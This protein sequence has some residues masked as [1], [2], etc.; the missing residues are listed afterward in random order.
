LINDY[1]KVRNLEEACDLLKSGN[2]TVIGGGTT[3]FELYERG[4]LQDV[5]VFVDL[6]KAGLDYIL[7][8]EAHYRIGSC[9]TF[10]RLLEE[11]TFLRNPQYMS[12]WEAIKAV[13][14]MQVRNVATISGSV[15]SA[16]PFYDPPVALSSLGAKVV[17]AGSNGERV[18]EVKDF[19]TG[20]LSRDLNRELVKELLL[21][22]LPKG[23]GS[24]FIKFGRTRF[25][26]GL[27][28]VSCVV[29]VDEDG[30]IKSAKV[31][32]GNYDQKPFE[33]VE[34]ERALL[35]R[36]PEP[37]YLKGILRRLDETTP[38]P[39]IHGSS[40]YKKELAKT[41]TIRSILTAYERA[42]MGWRS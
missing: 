24:S 32:L 10:S 22:K 34:V 13:K 41:L 31:F 11:G 7:E 37:N 42:M 40:E 25:D 5:E 15:C 17:I 26:Y 29:S 39:S 6:E 20:F 23:V 33:V 19:I 30:F 35:D 18:K 36:R 1:V 3:I 28:T 21:P 27:V 38:I 9:V 12:L 4:L 8:D 2:A 16:I 14:P